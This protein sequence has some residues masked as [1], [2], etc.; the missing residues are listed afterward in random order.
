MRYT[1]VNGY[2]F[3][4]TPDFSK[5]KVSIEETRRGYRLRFWDDTTSIPLTA[6]DL[7]ELKNKIER[8]LK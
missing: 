3:A 2:Q 4:A 5:P 6:D 1:S 7:R 8:E